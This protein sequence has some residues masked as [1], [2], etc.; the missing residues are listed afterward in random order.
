MTI[1]MVQLKK[2]RT[3]NSVSSCSSEDDV[4]ST[5]E[6]LNKM[7]P[8]KLHH[9]LQQ[10]KLSYE[11]LHENGYPFWDPVNRQAIFPVTANNQRDWLAGN[12]LIRKCSRCNKGF[13]LNSDGTLNPSVCIYH[14]RPKWNPQTGKKQRT[15]CSAKPSTSGCLIE[16][17]HVFHSGWEDTLWDFVSTPSAKST[18]F[19]SKKV[20]GLDCELVFTLNGLEVARV[21][22]VDMKGKVILDTY[23]LPVYEVISYNTTFSGVTEKDMEG[24]ISL[25]ACRLQLFQLINSETLLVGHS[26]ESD[27]KAL[28]IVHHNVIDTSVLF[29]LRN[30]QNGS[31]RKFSLQTLAWQHLT[32]IVQHDKS[33]HSSVE[34]GLTCL[35]LLSSLHMM[36]VK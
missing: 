29:A 20:Y 33:G 27:L 8:A 11:Q 22:L 16:N 34:D 6:P 4:S 5:I 36:S 1:E 35:E 24:A 17:S 31:I 7:A 10:W 14:H 23:V 13:S 12:D 3:G 21:S 25:E 28:R 30:M 9:L 2:K 26:L 18:D 15:C 32:K 19:R